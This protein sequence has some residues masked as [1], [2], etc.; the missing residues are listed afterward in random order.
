MSSTEGRLESPRSRM[1]V[2]RSVPTTARVLA[3]IGES[4]DDESLKNYERTYGRDL[5]DSLDSGKLGGMRYWR[6]LTTATSRSHRE[7]LELL[8]LEEYLCNSPAD[9]SSGLPASVRLD[10]TLHTLRQNIALALYDRA[11][12]LAANHPLTSVRVLQVAQQYLAVVCA[13]DDLSRADSLSHFSGRLAVATLMEARFMNVPAERIRVA[14]ERLKES[15]DQG[16]DNDAAATYLAEGLMRL[17]DGT[18]D[19]GPLVEAIRLA[20]K[21]ATPQM[22]LIE[23]QCWIRMAQCAETTKGKNDF[24]DR[25]AT[26]AASLAG[27]SSA[28]PR[29]GA[30]PIVGIQGALLRGLI[31][32]ARDLDFNVRGLSLPFGL[33]RHLRAWMRGDPKRAN[34]YVDKLIESY[35]HDYPEL[36]E[37]RI[38]SRMVGSLLSLRAEMGHLPRDRRILL[39]EE[40]CRLRG[41]S[42][43]SSRG[44]AESQLETALDSIRLYNLGVGP[45]RLVDGIASLFELSLSDEQWPLPV[46]LLAETVGR[47]GPWPDAL[48]YQL[49]QRM[50]AENEPLR[51]AIL[52]QDAK[53]LYA[54]AARRALASP[55]VERQTIGG[56][57]GVFRAADYTGLLDDAFLFKPTY[58]ELAAR[59]G[60]RTEVLG[61]Y[62]EKRRVSHFGVAET[63]ATIP[64]K[65]TPQLA[66]N[67][68]AVIVAKRFQTGTLLSDALRS[69]PERAP[70][71]LHSA[72]KFLA[73]IQACER[74]SYASVDNVRR[75]LWKKEFGYWLR[76]G[77]RCEDA[78][79]VFARW[80]SCVDALIQ[81]PRRDAHCLNWI[82]ADG[83]D[84]IAVDFE[85]LGS[86]PLGYELA[87]L[88]DDVPVLGD[89]VDTWGVRKSIVRSYHNALERE[90]LPVSLQDVMRGYEAGLVARAVRLLTGAEASEGNRHHGLALLN[91]A[92]RRAKDGRLRVVSDELLTAWASRSAGAGGGRRMSDSR[93][94]HLSRAMAY[95]LRHGESVF[96]DRHGWAYLA[97]VS[98]AL[99]RD[100]L[101]TDKEELRLI[102]GAIDEVRFQVDGP[103][104]RATYGH[105][106]TVVIERDPTPVGTT[107]YHGT[108]TSNLASILVRQEGLRPMGRNWVHMSADIS[109]A[110]RAARR[111]GAYTLLRFV[112]GPDDECFHAGG[113]THLMK[114]VD[115]SRLQIVSPSSFLFASTPPLEPRD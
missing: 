11:R 37:S 27:A 28:G 53:R 24:L 104:V 77:L 58:G 15:I 56:R 105:S 80:W 60:N 59:D 111:H 40:A 76:S 35:E 95:Q 23:S 107:V 62:L 102:A 3:W 113:S 26:K 45:V 61:N 6:L 110:A 55:E 101:G 106:R 54:L 96:V 72:A 74:D 21:V 14:I 33:R 71:L 39:I 69:E 89:P 10:K 103:K 25:A 20:G 8:A 52:S 100:G 75:E 87:Q 57:N 108:A 83:G 85:A 114:A 2:E 13:H 17:S 32:Q 68:N 112:V 91:W 65:P 9:V 70:D 63:I 5:L 47:G 36:L 97:A 46:L 41:N 43:T 34:I 4:I 19:R 84:L 98:D 81:V 82:L 48:R 38:G 88:T 44:A 115:A 50:Q 93:R 94:R 64:V 79:E 90:G 1:A 66:N 31:D 7:L 67:P 22:R 30:S 99:R 73:L 18:S 92:K 49:G 42:W 51:R 86:R 78:R 16:N 109:D 29:A 12:D